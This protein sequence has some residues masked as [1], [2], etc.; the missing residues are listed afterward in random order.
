M[1]SSHFIGFVELLNVIVIYCIIGCTVKFNSY[2]DLDYKS[3]A[4]EKAKSAVDLE[5]P[6]NQPE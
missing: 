4:E 6:T 2:W 5:G 1:H 3:T